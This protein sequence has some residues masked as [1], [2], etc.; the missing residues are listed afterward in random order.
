MFNGLNS[1]ARDVCKK[2]IIDDQ[3]RELVRAFNRALININNNSLSKSTKEKLK[4]DSVIEA[5]A[6]VRRI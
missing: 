2:Y 5:S 4:S 1:F 3:H 6:E